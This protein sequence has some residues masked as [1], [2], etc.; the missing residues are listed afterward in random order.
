MFSADGDEI[1]D[2]V[3]EDDEVI[4]QIPRRDIL[5]LANESNSYLRAV[6]LFIQRP[7][8]DIYLPRRSKDKDIAPGGYDLSVAGHIFSGESYIQACVR[9]IKEETGIDATPDDLKFIKRINPSPD[10]FYFRMLYLL[11]TDKIPTL[12]SEHAEFKW[13]K[14]SELD[15]TIRADVPTKGTLIEDIPVLLTYLERAAFE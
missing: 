5:T 11:R 12:S 13:V 9:E 6:E 1:L 8:G 14:P 2:V 3:N 15:I 7:N 4:R 10:L